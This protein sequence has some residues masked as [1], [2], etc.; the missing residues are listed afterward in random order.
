MA[1]IPARRPAPPGPASAMPMR[2][3]VSSDRRATSG[4]RPSC[5]SRRSASAP[6]ANER[7]NQPSW[8]LPAATG[9][10]RSAT[11]VI[12]PSAPSEPTTSSRSDG[13]AAV[14]GAPS[15]AS[16]PAGVAQRSATT[17]SSIRPCPVE[18]WPAERVATQP[19]TVAHSKLWGTCASRSPC[20][21]RAR[22][23]S[24]SRTP[25]ANTAVSERSSTDSR[26]SIR[27][28][29]SDTT[30]AKP[31]R[32]ASRPPTTLV[33]PPNGTTATPCS[34]QTRRTAA[35]WS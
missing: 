31:S 16:S 33:P 21:P 1:A 3:S 20:A 13:P 7:A 19:P 27:P 8:R 30:P 18:D 17:F 32:G 23:A 11:R 2:V 22:S 34:A 9:R 14:P 12:T 35:T 26:R 29:S 4:A 5:S 6:S 24:G 15:V 25:G 10:T 28:R